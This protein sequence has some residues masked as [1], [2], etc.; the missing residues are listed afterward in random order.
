MTARIQCNKCKELLDLKT[1]KPISIHSVKPE[2]IKLQSREIEIPIIGNSYKV[3]Y[4]YGDYKYL[5]TVL[6]NW[7][8][9]EVLKE[10]DLEAETKGRDGLTLY[11]RFCHPVIWMPIL[12]KNP[13]T[14]SVLCHEAIHACKHILFDK[15]GENRQVEETLEHFVGE[16]V[17]QV[18]IKTKKPTSSPLSPEVKAL[19][20]GVD[21]EK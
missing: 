17:R 9:R 15:M 6:K 7:K 19:K 1:L 13:Y 2:E 12:P 11:H 8:Y 21:K 16:V 10:I 18:L 4:C 20:L 14:I 3:I 5:R